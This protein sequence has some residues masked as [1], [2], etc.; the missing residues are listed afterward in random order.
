[1]PIDPALLM[2]LDMTQS[3]IA[4]PS[5]P[6]SISN[7]DLRATLAASGRPAFGRPAVG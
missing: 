2:P 4:D 3:V 7:P 6:P 5:N 1:V